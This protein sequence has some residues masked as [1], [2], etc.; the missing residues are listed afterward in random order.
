MAPAQEAA[1]EP[2]EEVRGPQGL[3]ATDRASCGRQV[4][5]EVLK[6]LL[7]CHNTTTAVELTD[8]QVTVVTDKSLALVG[9]L[10]LTIDPPVVA[11]SIRWC[12]VRTLPPPPLC[13]NFGRLRH[14]HHCWPFHSRCACSCMCDI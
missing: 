13:W 14:K 9:T 4:I 11:R 8:N 7:L 6:M 1:V 10:P 3:V 2:I 12:G 5:Q